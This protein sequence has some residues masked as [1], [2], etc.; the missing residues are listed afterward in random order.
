MFRPQIQKTRILVILAAFNLL[1]FYGSTQV[2]DDVLS[3]GY[4]EKIKA[5][6][7]M[8]S[9]LAELKNFRMEKGVFVDLSLIHI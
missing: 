5:T 9:A 7:I 1:L 8:A 3:R 2:K 4:E 6:E